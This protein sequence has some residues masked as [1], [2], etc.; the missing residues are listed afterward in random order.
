MEA[1]ALPRG[2]YP[3]IEAYRTGYLSLGDDHEMYFEEAGNPAGRPVLFL[4][5][6]PGGA[7]SPKHRQ[8][9]D[10]AKYRVILFDQRGCGKSRPHASLVANTTWHLIDDIER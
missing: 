9:F 5:G 6:G 3:P 10:P 2:L 4:H 1:G 8:F 7:C